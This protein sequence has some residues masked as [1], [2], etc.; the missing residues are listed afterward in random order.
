VPRPL[1]SRFGTA[2]I[3]LGFLAAVAATAPVLAEDAEFV[4]PPKPPA[5]GGTTL[6]PSAGSERSRGAA[7]APTPAPAVSPKPPET[8]SGSAGTTAGKGPVAPKSEV[9]S[10]N[11][12]AKTKDDGDARGP[13]PATPQQPNQPPKAQAARKPEPSALRVLSWAGAYGAAQ[14]I[15][16]FKTL[17]EDFATPVKRIE[18]SAEGDGAA[19]VVEVDQLA[20]HQGC[21]SGKFLKI[22][23]I[24][25]APGANGETPADDFVAG[26]LSPC[27]VATFAWSALFVVDENGFKRRKPNRLADV[28]RPRRYPGK[29]VFIANAPHVVLLTALASGMPT[30]KV[31]DTLLTQ[32]G[33]D[34]VFK[35]LES[36]RDHIIWA[37]N[38]KDALALLSDKKAT[39]AMTFSGRLFR[40]VIAG[41][42]EP[43]W[44]GHVYDFAAWAVRADTKMEREAKAFIVAATTPQRLAAQARY[45]PYGPMRRSAVALVGRHALVDVELEPYLPTAPE[46]L[47]NGILF[48]AAFWATNKAYFD[49]RLKAFRDGFKFGVRVPAPVRAPAE[50]RKQTELPQRKPVDG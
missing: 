2:A 34:T 47:K 35:M 42:I 23:N 1:I 8:A 25:L 10:A 49:A 38:S 19:D 3:S 16:I 6:V 5:T 36:L 33:A 41:Q 37:D 14:K 27:G 29:R 46:R 22:P 28:F 21:A 30:D 9:S 44:D 31:Y 26:G 12:K 11:P 13:T 17:S 40:K 18:R 50:L 43:I 32:A 48:D 15:G 20:L 7:D 45:F 39:M 4:D 24:V